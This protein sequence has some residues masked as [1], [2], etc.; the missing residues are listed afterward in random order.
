MVGRIFPSNQPLYV[1]LTPIGIPSPPNI[2]TREGFGMENV[3]VTLDWK[4][5]MG[6]SYNVIIN[7]NVPVKFVENTSIQLVVSY[8]TLYNVSVV[9]TSCGH[10]N[11]M[12]TVRL[13]YGE[14]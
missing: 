8:N 1:V 5:E 4:P 14:C 9:A 6:M 2:T 13:S 7:P 3:T 12:A 10:S 11:V